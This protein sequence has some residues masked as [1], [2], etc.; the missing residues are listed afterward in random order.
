MPLEVMDKIIKLLP[1]DKTIIDTFNGSGTTALACIDNDRKY[2]GI[3][4]EKEYCD[5]TIRRIETHIKQ[6][7]LEI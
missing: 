5:L 1:E 4:I 7:R 2:I 6:E 3:E